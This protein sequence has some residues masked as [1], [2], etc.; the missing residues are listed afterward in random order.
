MS[1]IRLSAVKSAELYSAIIS[2]QLTE[3]KAG[4]AVEQVRDDCVI[5]FI[6]KRSQ[7]VSNDA[8]VALANEGRIV[9]AHQIAEHRN[10]VERKANA[11]G[12]LYA[13]VPLISAE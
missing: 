10:Q 11:V 2:R 9:T 6:G 4:I 12:L 13:K 7:G 1:D 8:L 3:N 5:F